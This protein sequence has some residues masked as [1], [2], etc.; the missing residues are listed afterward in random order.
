LE[1]AST[2]WNLMMTLH[3]LAALAA[4]LI[5][6]SSLGLAPASAQSGD[7]QLTESEQKL[8]C[9]QLAGRIQVRLLQIRDYAERDGASLF[10]RGLQSAFSN[11]VGTSAKGLDPEGRHDRDL[12]VITAY[13][14]QLV[15]KGCKSYDLA[16]ELS[17]RGARDMPVPTVPAV[18][19]NKA[20]N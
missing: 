4:L 1:L 20:K 8:S 9:K 3:K 13:N 14:R 7:Y 17:K 11:T 6:P 5:L 12:M 19:A 2:E 16:Q 10:S 15:A 18:K